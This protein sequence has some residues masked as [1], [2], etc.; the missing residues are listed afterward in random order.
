MIAS[1][2]QLRLTTCRTPDQFLLASAQR[3]GRIA[4]GTWRSI[5]QTV[6]KPVGT[7]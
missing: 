3:D 7:G 1:V 5:W 6:H 4:G 2:W